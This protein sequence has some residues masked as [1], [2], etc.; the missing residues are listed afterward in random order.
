MS[1]TSNTGHLDQHRFAVVHSGLHQMASTGDDSGIKALPVASYNSQLSLL[2]G[3]L[4]PLLLLSAF[5]LQFR[6]L[7][8]NPESALASTLAPL[9]LS[10]FLYCVICL[11]PIRSIDSVKRTKPI[12]SERKKAGGGSKV[13]L[14]STAISA[15]L[16]VGRS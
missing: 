6:D 14:G 5:T 13:E 10:Q 15:R 16:S 12:P 1:E 4:H 2:Y 11:P 8:Q 7:V 3:H 9:A